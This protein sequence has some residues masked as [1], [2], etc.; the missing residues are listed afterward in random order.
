MKIFRLI[1][2]ILFYISIGFG[3]DVSVEQLQEY[4]YPVGDQDT[5][6]DSLDYWTALHINTYSG[7][8]E[9]VKSL[10]TE[11]SDVNAVTKNQGRTPLMMASALGHKNIFHLLLQYGAKI[12]A[13][14]NIGFT[15]LLHSATNGR[16]DMSSLLID[17]GADVFIKGYKENLYNEI[18]L[19][20]IS[21]MFDDI[22]LAKKLIQS[23]VDINGNGNYDNNRVRTPLMLAVEHGNIKAVKLLLDSRADIN[24]VDS[25]GRSALI[26]GVM[27]DRK[28]IINLLLTKNAN[29]DVIVPGYGDATQIAKSL[30]KFE[31]AD[32]IAKKRILFLASFQFNSEI[33]YFWKEKNEIFATIVKTNGEINFKKE[34][35]NYSKPNRI[36]S[37][38]GLTEYIDNDIKNNE[39]FN[40]YLNKLK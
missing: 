2:L 11:G 7:N 3:Q 18:L 22:V 19:L 26:Y 12:D 36:Y 24:L 40:Y 20:E 15:A 14:D 31:L 23:D 4:Y 16:L 10:I 25:L 28:E 34:I 5:P 6:P 1:I 9:K 32:F 13:Q 38:A 37:I 21:I 17:N 29:P 30:G 8:Y 35:F 27:Y 39:S 33:I